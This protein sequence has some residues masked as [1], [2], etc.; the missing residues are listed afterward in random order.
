MPEL[1]EVETVMRGL[2]ECLPGRRIVEVWFGKTDFIEQPEKLA[3]Q[4]SRALFRG[5]ERRGKFLLLALDAADTNG[6]S[7]H[8]LV[9]LGMTGQLTVRRAEEIAPPHTHVVM[10]LDDG[11]ELR[12]TDPRRFGKMRLVVGPLAESELGK[13]GVEPLEA[14]AAEFAKKIH[15]RRTRIKALLLDQRVLRGL[16]N[17]YTDESLWRARIHPARQEVRCARKNCAASTLRS[18]GFFRTPY[19]CAALRFP[20]TWTRRAKWENTSAIIAS[21]IAKVKNAAAAPRASAASSSPAAAAISVPAASAPRAS[22]AQM[23]RKQMGGKDNPAIADECR[24]QN[25]FTERADPPQDSLFPRGD[26]INH[27]KQ[28]AE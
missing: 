2:R 23:E 16:G 12:Y 10:R 22:V 14:S 26:C 18:A 1:P 28:H 4:L 7:R 11:R 15:S 6:E 19:A 17:I 24:G 9:H 13:L 27:G 25:G 20:T 5:V 3:A 8:L 21:T